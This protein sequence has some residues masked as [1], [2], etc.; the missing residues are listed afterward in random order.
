[1][2]LP[3]VVLQGLGSGLRGL[4]VVCLL[5]ALMGALSGFVNT[6][7]AF[8]VRDIYQNFLRPKAGN[9]E[10]IFS[11]YCASAGAVVTSFI[12]GLA[13]PSINNIWGW[14]TMGLL[15]GSIGPQMLRLYWWRINAWGMVLGTFSGGSAAMIQRAFDPAMTEWAQFS[16]MSG[17]SFL[18]TILGSLLTKPTP[19][20]VVS[21]F[22]HTTRPFGFWG[23]FGKN[24]R[25]TSRPTGGASI[26][27]TSYRRSASWSGRSV[28][29]CCPCSF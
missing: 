4:L 24:C 9:R 10:L 20:K 6:A 26:A 15:A 25:T 28:C 14:L 27:P 5:A 22:Y 23:A 12:M 19:H 16:L 11:A 1:M 2:V 29:L 13:A 17:I 3:T 8:F 21:H 18:G 7:S